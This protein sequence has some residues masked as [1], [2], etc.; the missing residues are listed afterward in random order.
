MFIQRKASH[1]YKPGYFFG[2]IRIELLIEE[3]RIVGVLWDRGRQ[4]SLK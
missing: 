4:Y 1:G 3:F 2:K